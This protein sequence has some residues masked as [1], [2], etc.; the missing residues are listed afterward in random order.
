MRTRFDHAAKQ[1]IGKTLEP[2]GLFL[3]EEEV[4]P[5]PQRVDG[6][7]IP[8]PARAPPRHHRTLLD[9]M[10]LRPCCF[11]AF[12][13]PPSADELSECA[14]KILNLRHVL[15]LSKIPPAPPPPLGDLCRPP[16]RWPEGA[17]L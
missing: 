12:H 11:E 4:S 8:D 14:R 10:A 13:L 6:R 9:R 17:E 15:S 16:G 3:P 5:D 2:G 7:F 1:I